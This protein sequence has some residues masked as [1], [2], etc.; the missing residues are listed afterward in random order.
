MQVM[1]CLLQ[2]LC[3][4]QTKAQSQAQ[5]Q[6]LPVGLRCVLQQAH[7]WR[8]QAI[9]TLSHV[10]THEQHV[11][12]TYKTQAT[13]RLM[14]TAYEGDTCIQAGG[15]GTSTRTPCALLAVAGLLICSLVHRYLAP[16]K[17]LV[18]FGVPA[19][20]TVTWKHSGGSTFAW[21]LLCMLSA[22]VSM[23]ASSSEE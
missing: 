15:A 5:T 18:R 12:I 4:W 23:A 13:G 16:K 6:L 22:P 3:S 14:H 9:W 11:Y 7:E 20:P 2:T 21:A 1:L 8:P 10:L 19:L 17:N